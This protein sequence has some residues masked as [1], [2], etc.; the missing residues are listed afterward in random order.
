[1]DFGMGGSHKG[2][3][4]QDATDSNKRANQQKQQPA[5]TW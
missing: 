4:H 1:M 3:T 2:Q 5:K